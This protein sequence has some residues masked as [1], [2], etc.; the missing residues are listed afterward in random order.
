MALARDT[1]NIGKGLEKLD[2]CVQ[3]THTLANA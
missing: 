2:E 1:L 3:L